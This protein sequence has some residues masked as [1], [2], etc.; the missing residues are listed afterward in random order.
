MDNN[1]VKY[2]KLIRDKIPE[3]IEASGGKAIIEVLDDESYGK[4]L[5]KKLQEELKEY[6]EDGNVEELADL[7]EVIYALL[8]HKRVLLEEFEKIRLSKIDARGGFHKRLV[9]REVI[10]DTI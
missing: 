7:V 8:E 4:Y 6:L 1:S 2:D 10:K 9:L 5:D 3:I